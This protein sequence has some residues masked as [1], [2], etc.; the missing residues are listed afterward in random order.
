MCK[1]FVV[2]TNEWLAKDAGMVIQNLFIN[3]NM[4]LGSLFEES[5]A[6]ETLYSEDFSSRTLVH[7]LVSME[8]N[9]YIHV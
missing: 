2:N 3:F 4:L 8:K 6:L 1:D 7:F 9:F 5:K